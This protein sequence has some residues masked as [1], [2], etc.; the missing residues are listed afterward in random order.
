MGDNQSIECVTVGPLDNNV[1]LIGDNKE[2]IIIDAAA[3]EKKITQH[4]GERELKGI[5]ITHGHFDHIGAAT[6]LRSKHDAA[7]YLHPDDGF[8][9]GEQH[10]GARPNKRLDN[11]G[12][13]LVDNLSLRPLHTPGH[14]PGSTC[15]YVPELN[16]VFTGDTL[17]PDGPGAT[18]WAYSDFDQII[19]SITQKLFTLPDNT[20]V[21]PGHGEATDIKTEKPRLDSWI[22]RG[23]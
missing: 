5:V 19:Q 14:T 1:Y 4:I 12:W 7:V 2:V 22:K 15:Y 3:D 23:W 8:L 11:V 18:K 21:L 17:F 10:P 20:R 9:W 16:V 6:D 13:L